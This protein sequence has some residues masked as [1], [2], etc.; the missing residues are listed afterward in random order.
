[1]NRPTREE[2][3]G[4]DPVNIEM[5]ASEYRELGEDVREL[6]DEALSMYRAEDRSKLVCAIVVKRKLQVIAWYLRVA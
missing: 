5:H 4:L 1:M 6:W 3:E 2:R